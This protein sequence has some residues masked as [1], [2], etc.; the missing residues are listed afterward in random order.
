MAPFSEARSPAAC[1]GAKSRVVNPSLVLPLLVLALLTPSLQRSANANG[2][3]GLGLS[4]SRS[5]DAYGGGD[6]P[7]TLACTLAE[8]L[9]G[10][11]SSRPEL[12]FLS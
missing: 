11:A 6:R 4:Q 7:P 3:S 8:L 2:S 10:S 12:R 9:L 5:L 1:L